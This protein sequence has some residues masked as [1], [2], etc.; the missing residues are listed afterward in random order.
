[1]HRNFLHS[2]LP[3]T[4]LFLSM[5]T[6]AQQP[7]EL[8][9]VNVHTRISIN[10]YEYDF[11]DRQPEFPGGNNELIRFINQERRYPQDAYREG[12]EGR[13]LCS[14]VV[15]EDGTLSHISV[16]KGVEESLNKEAVRII[17][18]MPPWLAGAINDT[19]VPVYC[20]LPI[21]FRK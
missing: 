14:F 5:A 11:V 10:V 8:P 16:I 4:S 9:S 15:N 17:S 20:I 19:P 12:I 18:Q 3:I 13:V 1:M 21:P 7:K 2:I 6:F